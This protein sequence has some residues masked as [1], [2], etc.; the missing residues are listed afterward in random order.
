MSYTFDGPNKRIILGA[1]TTVLD[2]VDLHSRWKD[3]VLLGNAGYAQAFR[4]VG[5]DIPAI[6][7]YLFI[8]NDWKIVPQAANHTLTVMNGVLE[9]EGGGD[10]FVDPAGAYKIRINRQA[11]GIAIGY[12]ATGSDPVAIAAAVMSAAVEAGYS[13]KDVL[14]LMSAVLLGEVSGAGTGLEIFKGIDGATERVASQTDED[15][16]RI[17]VAYNAS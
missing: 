16:N 17:D 11:P 15:G 10:P 13:M 14:R 8:L 1:G 12:S 4:A 6:P 7:L 5:G 9:V 3:W 2:L